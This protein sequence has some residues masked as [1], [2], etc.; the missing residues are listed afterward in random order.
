MK[1]SLIAVEII[2]IVILVGVGYLAQSPKEGLP[3]YPGATPSE[4]PEWFATFESHGIS[5]SAYTT[6]ANSNEVLDWYRSEM[7]ER[8]WTKILDNTFDDSHILS[9]QKGNEGAGVMENKGTLILAHGTIEQLQAVVEEMY[10]ESGPPEIPVLVAHPG[11]YDNT[12]RINVEFGSILAGY[13]DYSVSSTERS[14]SWTTGTEELDSPH[15]TLGT[16]AQETYYVSLR[17]KPSGHIYF[18]DQEATI[19]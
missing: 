16:F 12:I 6:E 13:W 15:I 10:Q 4:V 3:V 11:I 1:K 9:F 14:Y 2:V 17:H 18:A 19:T 8:G 5:V 7:S